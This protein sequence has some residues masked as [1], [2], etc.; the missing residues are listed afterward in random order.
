M[1]KV[2]K[3]TFTPSFEL[4]SFDKS[5]GNLTY[6]NDLYDKINLTNELVIFFNKQK[7]LKRMKIREV[8]NYQ[9]IVGF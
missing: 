8:K 4:C 1:V 2:I 9:A 3:E 6:V 5:L 7:I